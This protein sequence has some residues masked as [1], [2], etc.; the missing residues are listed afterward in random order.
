MDRIVVTGGGTAGHVTPLLAV[1]SE[2]K[3]R[4]SLVK[5][6]Y[7]G[8]VGDRFAN[9]ADSSSVIDGS[10]HI[11][12]GKFRRFHGV[13]KAVYLKDPLLIIRN[14]RDLF[15][16]AF[17]FIQSMWLLIWWRPSVVFVKGGFVGLPVG[18]AAACLR[19]P[20]VTH[21]SDAVA[22]LTNRILSR[23]AVFNAVAMPA[24]NYEYAKAKVRHTGLPLRDSLEPVT[25]IIKS[26][27]RS[28]FELPRDAF[29]ITIVGGSLGAVRLNNAIMAI[30]HQLLST[31]PNVWLIHLT[32]KQQLK[33]VGLF[34]DALPPEESQRIL[35]WDFRDDL[36]NITAAS[37]LVVS[38]AGSSVFEFA[39][40][41]L[42]LIL[43]PNPVL[44]GGH[45]VVNARALEKIN[46]AK[47]VTEQSLKESNNSSLYIAITDL[48]AHQKQC[49]QLSD[50]LYEG[51]FVDNAAAK[52]VDVLYEAEKS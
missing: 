22:G 33:E 7:I 3:R 40:Q 27:A 45:Q 51:L 19:I 28:S 43:V 32:G 6:R 37:D 20:V 30:A 18:L 9:I 50:A 8:N 41:K 14:I 17:G 49:Q 29:V 5:I 47:V 42:P 12:A 39:A 34:Y 48:I 52:I 15:Y 35:Y 26:S 44:T 38:R 4:D 11:V 21:D 16:F 10:W 46:A 36:A 2:L 13:S 31:Y 1:A 23:F 24:N 25:P